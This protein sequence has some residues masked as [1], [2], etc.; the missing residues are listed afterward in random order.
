LPDNLRGSTSGISLAS[1][2]SA[3]ASSE[4][5]AYGD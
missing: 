4:Q 1:A 5:T 2:T 3:S